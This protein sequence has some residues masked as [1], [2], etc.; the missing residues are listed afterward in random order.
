[1][2]NQKFDQ[3]FVFLHLRYDT[4]TTK[5]LKRL[6]RKAMIKAR[7]S[8]LNAHHNKFLDAKE[9][10]DSTIF[11]AKLDYE[12]NLIN[13]IKTDPK[14]F[15]NYARHF[16]RSSSTVD[17]LEHD[18]MRVTEDKEK[19]DILND[20]F[21]SVLKSEPADQ[22]INFP[23]PPRNSSSSIYDVIIS[24]KIVREKL[25]KLHPNKASGP[26]GIHVNI[27]KNVLDFDVPLSILFE[28]SLVTG[29]V[30][31]DW[32]DANITPLF[33]KGSRLSPNNY[34]PVSLTS[35]I[36][37]LLE[38]IICDQL[39]EFIEEKQLISCE[40]HGFQKRCSCVTQLLECLSDWTTSF[41]EN[42]GVDVVYLDFRKAFDTVAH[43][44]LLYKLHHLGIRG[45][46]LGWL[47]SFL[48]H[49]RQRVILRN[50]SSEWRKVTSGVPQGSILGPILFLLF[51]NDIPDVISNKAKMFADDTKLYA[52]IM[53][54]HDCD[55]LQDDLNALSA[56]SKLWLLDFN[57]EKCVVLRI[58]AAIDY[59]Y[60]LNGVY[61]KEV[62]SQKDLGI[63]IC[64]TLSP[65]KHINEI[66]KKAH[67][68]IAMF[69]RCFTGLDEKKVSILYKSLVRP[70][71]EYAST[72]WSPKSKENINA[73]EKV[74]RRSLRLSRDQTIHMESL[75]E[76]RKK[77]ELVDTYKF[78]TGR[79]KTPADK[80][81]SLPH[82]E[83]RGHSKKVYVKR[84][85][86]QL[87]GHFY[88]NR[89]VDAWNKLPEDIISAP[90]V[91]SFKNKLR[92]L[93][94]GKED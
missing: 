58:K 67:Q 71:L 85:R 81:F 77:T 60:S 76:R 39:M 80:Y 10:V 35:Q 62:V 64:N 25:A 48:N 93:P 72:V 51:V 65:T 17:V 9:E 52:N 70:A 32:R 69:R 1:M 18:G 61:L 16:T 11:K 14:R 3:K 13:D 36:V 88:S 75:R 21:A 63:T 40:Q 84:T 54:K 7:K 37:K 38:K 89:V 44:R 27:M 26:D 28:K 92:V 4:L 45:H 19:A 15:Y 68:K 66:I 49:R 46:L 22:N 74:Q 47:E 34:R 59:Q 24:P 20:F 82:K 53:T 73:L 6:K 33:K 91:A 2:I 23:L 55:S 50:G 41:D 86:T 5:R 78:I 57:A 42:V 12:A 43:R 90:T 94:I 79:Y 8:G 83:L 29:V 31:Q 87:A 56:W 30:P